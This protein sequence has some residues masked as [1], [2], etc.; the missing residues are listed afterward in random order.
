MHMTKLLQDLAL[1]M[2]VSSFITIL[3]KRF[4]QPVVLGYILSGMLLGP[5]MLPNLVIQDKVTIKTLAEFG[6]IFLMFSLGLE[7]SFRKLFKVGAAACLAALA[8][9]TVMMVLGYQIGLFFHWGFLNSLFLGGMLA[10]SSTTIIIK[11][12]DELKL[13]G[14]KFAE[15]IFGILIIEDILAI[16]ILALLSNIALSGTVHGT[17]MALTLGKLF[18][19]LVGSLIVGLLVVPKLLHSIARLDSREMLLISVLALCFGFCFLVYELHYSV[20][21]GAFIIGA[22]MAESAELRMIEQLISPITDMFSALF[23]VSIGFLVDPHIMLLYAWPIVWISLIVVVGKILLC[24]CGVFLAGK[25]TR[26][27]LKVGMSLAQIGEFSFIIA[28]LGLTLKVTSAFLYPIIVAVSAI[29]TLLTPYLIRSAD[30][31]A[32]SIAKYTPVKLANYISRYTMTIHRLQHGY[33]RHYLKMKARTIKKFTDK[34][35]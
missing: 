12:L 24:S 19:F 22:I 28:S 21:L 32:Q 18:A 10:I 27:A 6:V 3:F 35:A 9:I 7:F 29:T 8:E 20:A 31:I 23:F 1:I 16:A 34:N 5:H 13:K 26:T 25:D 14:E 4:K 11:A 15:L 33:R 2:L 17:A 30:P